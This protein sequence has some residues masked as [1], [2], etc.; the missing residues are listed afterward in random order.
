MS[1]ALVLLCF[2][3][4]TTALTLPNANLTTH[5]T[6][7]HDPIPSLEICPFSGNRR[8]LQSEQLPSTHGYIRSFDLTRRIEGVDV[9]SISLISVSETACRYQDMSASTFE[10]RRDGT[11]GMTLLQAPVEMYRNW[12][13]TSMW[14]T[15]E[16]KLMCEREVESL[17]KR[18]AQVLPDLIRGYGV[19]VAISHDGFD[20]VM[21]KGQLSLAGF[22]IDHNWEYISVDP[23]AVESWQALAN[24]HQ[25]ISHLAE[26][27]GLLS[28]FLEPNEYY[29]LF[30]NDPG[31]RICAS[32]WSLWGKVKSAVRKGTY[33][34]S[35]RE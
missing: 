23:T 3:P 20:Y 12:K 34:S 2:T 13:G 28:A 32:R 30:A 22:T 8:F 33:N 16:D 6:R 10:V 18:I 5:L 15:F 1:A 35:I 29:G 31:W 25:A 21:P 27:G 19:R 14:Q 24:D 9:D 26:T 7:R 4:I 11:T 17:V